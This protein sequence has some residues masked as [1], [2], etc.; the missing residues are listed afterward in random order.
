[1]KVKTGAVV[2]GRSIEVE[3]SS[4]FDI[5]KKWEKLEGQKLF[6]KMSSYADFLLVS[7]MYRE[8]LIT[9]ELAQHRLSALKKIIDAE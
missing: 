8:N 7:Y 6:D 2:Q 4:E 1:M 9:P 3:I 5:P